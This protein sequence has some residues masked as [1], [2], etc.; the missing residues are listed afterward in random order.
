MKRLF[1]LL[2]V[3]ILVSAPHVSLCWSGKV[4]GV[5]DGDT[6]SV[7]NG[8]RAEKIRLFGIDCPESDQDFGTKAKKFTANM[9]FGKTVEVT[10]TGEA[11][12]GRTVAWVTMDGQA[13]NKELVRNG[14]AWW[15]RR[16]AQSETELKMLEAEAKA[17][18]I[19]LWSHPHPIP[20]WKFR[21]NQR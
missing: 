16:H 18:K 13:L 5:S 10:P 19:G 8:T 15:Y 1:R 21:R 4:V 12:Y 2:V 3:I 9:V 6:I 14:L 17:R 20:P 7:L 11:S